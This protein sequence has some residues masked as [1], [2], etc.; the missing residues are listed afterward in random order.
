MPAKIHVDDK[1]CL[2]CGSSFNRGTLP[3]GRLEAIQDFRKRKYCSKRCYWD[4]NSGENHCHYKDGKKRRADGYV[5]FSDDRYEHRVVMEE[6]LGRSLETHEHVHHINHDPS[7]N[8]IENL[9]LTTN[10]EH[11]KHHAKIQK[12]NDLGEFCA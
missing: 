9:E 1:E 3:S 8:R 12:R 7:D 4:N 2:S 6:K 11:R 10:S 5:R